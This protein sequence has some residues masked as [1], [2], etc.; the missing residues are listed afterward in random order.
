[1][2]S[3]QQ[4]IADL[5]GD[6]WTDD[7]GWAPYQFKNIQEWAEHVAEVLVSELGLIREHRQEHD[8][9]K[10]VAGGC[11]FLP[12]SHRYVTEWV[13]EAPADQLEEA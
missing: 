11:E 7:I 6:E 2:S 10:T 13:S 1:V 9:V 8:K 4:R 12:I 3:I 5:L